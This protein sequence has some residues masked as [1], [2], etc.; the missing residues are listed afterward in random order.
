[1][2]APLSQSSTATVRSLEVTG[3]DILIMQTLADR[4]DA[5][6]LSHIDYVLRQQ[7]LECLAKKLKI[8]QD[9]ATRLVEDLA[10][11]IRRDTENRF[12]KGTD[13]FAGIV[14]YAVLTLQIKA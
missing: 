11:R 4:F 3:N 12:C 1:M 2:I 9:E 13:C 14:G 7:L 5:K 6:D 10:L 8:S